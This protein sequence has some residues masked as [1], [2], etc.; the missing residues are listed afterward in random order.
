MLKVLRSHVSL[1]FFEGEWKILMT[2]DIS[3]HIY[4]YIPLKID[5]LVFRWCDNFLE[6]GKASPTRKTKIHPPKKYQEWFM[7]W[8]RWSMFEGLKCW[9]K[10]FVFFRGVEST[11]WE[12]VR[13]SFLGAGRFWGNGKYIWCVWWWF[14][15]FSWDVF[16]S[17]SKLRIFLNDEWWWYWE[18]QIF[19]CSCQM[20]WAVKL[21]QV[22]QWENEP[23]MV[24]FLFLWQG[25]R[26]LAI[27]KST[28]REEHPPSWDMGRDKD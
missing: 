4:I 20:I 9:S 15:G 6:Q 16:F 8:F 22:L 21:S 10:P 18:D 11:V 19:A 26:D 5:G 7:G 12:L 17:V 28:E 25:L 24:V 3:T 13:M 23:V 27:Q 1:F 14:G 2:S